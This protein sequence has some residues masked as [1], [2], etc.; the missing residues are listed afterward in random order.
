MANTDHDVYVTFKIKGY[1]DDFHILHDEQLKQEQRCS[2]RTMSIEFTKLTDLLVCIRTQQEDYYDTA[3]LRFKTDIDQRRDSLNELYTL[4]GVDMSLM[5][6][7]YG[8]VL[9]YP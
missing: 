1:V 6:D 5:N 3:E 9:T 8:A 2:I 7:S 4:L